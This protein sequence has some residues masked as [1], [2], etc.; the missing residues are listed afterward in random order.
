MKDSKAGSI[1]EEQKL[2][3][4]AILVYGLLDEIDKVRCGFGDESW[5]RLDAYD[6]KLREALEKQ[7]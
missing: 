1:D 5:A 6:Y 2:N 3:R 4:I 7:Q